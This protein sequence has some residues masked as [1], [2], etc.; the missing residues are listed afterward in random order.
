MH[1]KLHL[2]YGFTKYSQEKVAL[3]LQ[4]LFNLLCLCDRSQYLESRSHGMVDFAYKLQLHYNIIFI[5]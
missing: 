3:W 2:Y 5:P 4:H 1:V